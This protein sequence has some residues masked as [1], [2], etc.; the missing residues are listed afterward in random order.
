MGHHVTVASPISKVICASDGG[1]RRPAGDCIRVARA[2]M[3]DQEDVRTRGGRAGGTIPG[4]GTRTKKRRRESRRHPPVRPLLAP[5][6]PAQPPGRGPARDSGA[7]RCPR[8]TA[9]PAAAQASARAT[10]AGPRYDAALVT[11]RAALRCGRAVAG[12]LHQCQ[13]RAPGRGASWRGARAGVRAAGPRTRG[14]VKPGV[15]VGAASG[16]SRGAAR[17]GATLSYPDA[18]TACPRSS[19]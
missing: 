18:R 4:R 6:R 2:V 9:A 7:A 3:T 19:A 17:R 14:T 16:R 12:L 11:L 5:A 13:P 15:V 8:G 10:F 1:R